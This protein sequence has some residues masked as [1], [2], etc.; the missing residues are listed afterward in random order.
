MEYQILETTIQEGKSVV[1]D[2]NFPSALRRQR[3]IEVA[4]KNNVPCV[5]FLLETSQLLAKHLNAY[6]NV[7]NNMSV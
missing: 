3:I 6:A 4:K 2:G 7:G 1:V 5:C